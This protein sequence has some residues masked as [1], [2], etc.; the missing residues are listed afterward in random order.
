MRLNTFWAAI[1]VLGT[2]LG[3]GTSRSVM[4]AR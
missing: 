2:V 1:L 3:L 4:A